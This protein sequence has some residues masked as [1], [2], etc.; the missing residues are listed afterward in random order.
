[1]IRL[2]M[3]P[4][5]K[6]EY[7]RTRRLEAKVIT[8][9]LL[10]SAV[11]VGLVIVLALWVYGAQ[12]LHKNALT[13]TIKK[14]VAELQGVKDID[15]Y[16]TI[17]NQLANIDS[18]HEKKMIYSRLFAVLPKLNPQA[19]NTVRIGGLIIDS[20]TNTMM[21]EGETSS[22]TALETFRDTLKNAK[23]IYG[24]TGSEGT[25]TSPLFSTVTIDTQSIGKDAEAQ[26]VVSFKLTTAYDPAWFVRSTSTVDVSVPTKET[27]QSKVDAP[28]V[29]GESTIKTEGAQ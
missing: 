3:L 12:T 28:D 11:A 25:T 8:G 20:T 6:R 24:T 7:L 17:Q 18:L 13:G 21:F 26:T 10:F 27:T 19:P 22:F 14:N 1:M 9:A 2:N 5:V 29:F 4:D 23:L 16:V 15:K